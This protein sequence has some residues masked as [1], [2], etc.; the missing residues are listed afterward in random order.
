MPWAKLLWPR[1]HQ[2]ELLVIDLLMWTARK[3]VEVI[4]FL[5]GPFLPVCLPE[6]F[7]VKQGRI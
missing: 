2:E 6:T 3:R 1:F 7:S 4:L 5:E